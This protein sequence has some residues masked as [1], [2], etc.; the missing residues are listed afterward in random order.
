MKFDQLFQYCPVC[1]SDNFELNNIKSK[2]CHACGFVFYVN[3]AAAVAGFILNENQELLVCVRAHDP[4]KGTWDLP[5]GF[6]D[7]EESAEE[8]LRREIHEELQ[9]DVE[10]ARILFTLPNEYL[11]SGW[12]TPTLD[13][14]FSCQLVDSERI[15]ASDDVAEVFYLPLKEIDP[16]KFG[17]KS[18]REAVR[19]FIQINH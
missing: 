18:V 1:G 19:K 9:A 3:P 8:A 17:L 4:E 12:T 6:I 15:K 11:Y 16:E 13:I 5:G 2:K 7:D 14:F 10:T